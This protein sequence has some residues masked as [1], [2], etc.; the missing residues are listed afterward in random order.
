MSNDATPWDDNLTQFARLISELE[1][2]GCF[3]LDA[4]QKLQSSMDLDESQICELIERAQTVWEQRK[5]EN[6]K[7]KYGF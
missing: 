5:R 3:T 1:A 7:A 2:E 6:L 4:M